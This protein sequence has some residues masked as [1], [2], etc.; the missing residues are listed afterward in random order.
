[1]RLPRVEYAAF[2]EYKKDA[3]PPAHCCKDTRENILDQIEKWEEGYDENC[4][5]WLSGMAGTGKFT[6]ARTVANM[7]YQKNRL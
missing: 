7:F 6:I 4:V 5:F 3:P 2:N 1:M